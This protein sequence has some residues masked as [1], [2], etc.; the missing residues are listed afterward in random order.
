MNELETILTGTSIEHS[1]SVM[2]NNPDLLQVAG[3][4][5][6]DTDVTPDSS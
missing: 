4:A 3:V 1:D 2:E 5:N 6:A